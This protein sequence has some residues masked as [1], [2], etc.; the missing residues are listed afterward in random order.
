M[1]PFAP[2]SAAHNGFGNG[3]ARRGPNGT[4]TVNLAVDNMIRNQ[5]K[6]SNVRDPKQIADALLNYYKDLPLAAA[7]REE[8]QGLPLSQLQSNA[9]LPP[10]QPTSSDAEFNIANGDVEK[11]LNDLTT[12]ALT[13]DIVPE[14]LGWA[15][16]IRRGIAQGHIAARN[17]LDPTQR[18]LVFGIRRQLGEYARLA[19]FVGSMSPAL[20]FN[21][22]RLAQGLDE[23]AAVLLVMLGE[24]LASVGFAS[25][26]YLL[27]VPLAE[28]QQRRDA[29]IFALRIF[30]GGA[31]EAYGPNDWPR[32][33]D[34][35]RRVYN[36]LEEQGQGDLRSLLIENEI[37]Q[38]MDA[39]ISRAQNG[40]AEGLRALG[41]T[42]Q[43]DIE[44]FRRMAIVA[45]GALRGAHGHLDRSPPL[46]AYLQALELFYETFRPAGGLR[47]LRIAR[48]AILFYGLY[49]PNLLEQDQD[50]LQLVNLRGYFGTVFDAL[51]PGAGIRTI[52]PQV[53]LDM[54][55]LEI[56]RAMDLLALGPQAE[57]TDG[58]TELRAKAYWLIINVVVNVLQGK[59]VPVI[60]GPNPLCTLITDKDGT[61]IQITDSIP[62]TSF[63]DRGSVRVHFPRPFQLGDVQQSASQHAIA[64]P[65]NNGSGSIITIAISNVDTGA[66][67]PVIKGH[68]I[69]TSPDEPPGPIMHEALANTDFRDTVNQIH[70]EY[71]KAPQS[72]KLDRAFRDLHKL[73]KLPRRLTQ[74]AL[75]PVGEELFVQQSLEK[76]WRDL[77]RTIAP[78]A[79]AQVLIFRLLELVIEQAMFDAQTGDYDA[80]G[81]LREIRPQPLPPQYEQ[82]LEQIAQGIR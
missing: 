17:G 44:R 50:L 59:H 71:A 57:A 9:M 68:L 30:M 67:A 55:L 37:A 16:S 54:T 18:D 23:V 39:L 6:V 41:V 81:L 46:E 49:N 27:Q 51:F 36:W 32:G 79:G 28:V 20:T 8:A 3:A 14:M 2:N 65:T 70:S 80:S 82:T 38:T 33:I 19:R 75:I 72:A 60:G 31:Q 45:P 77:V 29:V 5:L 69:Y 78:E 40:T 61:Q 21:Y 13:N 10:A 24:S 12:N 43:L 7:V 74:N 58:K 73:E 25:G 4:A 53:L 63:Q 52:E 1:S 26:Y 76:R 62:I 42:A 66:S 35:Y 48:P 11:A 34:A 47:L 64:S 56:D 22:R 15:D